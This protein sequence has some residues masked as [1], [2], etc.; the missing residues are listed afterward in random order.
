MN[1]LSIK[2]VNIKPFLDEKKDIQRYDEGKVFV[3]YKNTP[4]D[5]FTILH[6][7]I[8]AMNQ[9][10]QDFIEFGQNYIKEVPSIIIE[11]LLGKWLLKN[12]III[13]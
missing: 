4:E 11:R 2:T 12:K 9:V 1:I 7:M 3:Y 8:H 13:L 10:N 5:I 6:E